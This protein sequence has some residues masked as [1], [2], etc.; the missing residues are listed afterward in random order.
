[1]YKWWPSPILF[2]AAAVLFIKGCTMQD[3]GKKYLAEHPHDGGVMGIRF[4]SMLRVPSDGK[5]KVKSTR[6]A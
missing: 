2:V 5:P 6:V 3:N 1:M 4:D